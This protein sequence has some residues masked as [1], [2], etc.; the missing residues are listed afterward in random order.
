MW[1]GDWGT[2]GAPGSAAAPGTVAAEL[3][4]LGQCVAVQQVA[5]DVFHDRHELARARQSIIEGSPELKEG[6]AHTMGSMAASLTAA[7]R[8]K[9][10]AD[11]LPP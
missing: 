10:S 11:P 5:A 1:F 8:A 4:D 9:V 7:L 6:E 2:A 3:F